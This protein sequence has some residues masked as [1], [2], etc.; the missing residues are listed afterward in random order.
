MI[1]FVDAYVPAGLAWLAEWS[2]RWGVLIALLAAWFAVCPPRRAATRHLLSVVALMA[3]LLLP[4][5]PR[6]GSGFSAPRIDPGPVVGRLAPIARGPVRE[7]GPMPVEPRVAVEGPRGPRVEAP[8]VRELPA[9][10]S[11]LKIHPLLV[12]RIALLAVAACWAA[13]AAVVLLRML[14]GWA[15]LS[16]MRGR[17]TPAGGAAEGLFEACRAELGARRRARLAGHEAVGSPIAVGGWSPVVLVPVDWDALPAPVQRAGLLHELAHLE[18]GDDWARLGEEFVRAAFWFHPG[19]LWLLG[20]IDRERELLCDEAA[21]ARGIAPRE[22]ARML[23]DFAKRPRVLA[24]AP[25]AIPFLSRGT[26]KARIDR[27]L[28]DDVTRWM[29]PLP[30]GRAMLLGL[31]ILG[32][33]LGA[34]SLRV[35]GAGSTPGRAGGPRED[36]SK[37]GRARAPKAG[38]ADAA[39]RDGAPPMKNDEPKGEPQVTVRGTVVDAETGRPITRFVEQ[40]GQVDPK[41]P[42]RITWGFTETRTEGENL[43]GTFR[44]TLGGDFRFRIRIL[45]DGYV[46]QPV[47]VDPGEVGGREV[48]VTVKMVRGRQVSG[49]VLDHGGRPVKAT[50]F[51]VGALPLNITGGQALRSFGGEETAATKS[52]T[53]AEGRFA[54]A[55]RGDGQDRVAVS[56]PGV[57]DLW[58]VPA[59]PPGEELTVRLPEPGRLVLR[60]DI[61]GSDDEARFLLQH[62]TWEQKGWDRLDNIRR[63]TA[64]NGGGVVLSDLTPGVYSLTRSRALRVGDMGQDVLC[65]RRTITVESGKDAETTF[66]RDRGQRVSGQVVGLDLERVTGA[67]IYVRPAEAT[68]DPRAGD[69]WEMPTF[70]ALTCGPNGRFR[71]GRLSPGEYTVV[72]EVYLPEAPEQRRLSGLRVADLVGTAKV[73]VPEEGAAPEVRIELKPRPEPGAAAKDEGPAWG[74]SAEGVQCRLKADKPRWEE[75]EVP[76]LKADVRNQGTQTLSV[77]QAQE[78]CELEVDGRW[79]FWAGAIDIKSSAFGPGRLYEGIRVTLDAM[80]SPKDGGALLKLAPGRHTVR[81][82]FLPSRTGEGGG[83]AIRA[84]SEPVEVEIAPK[85]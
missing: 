74:G 38:P 22:F 47:A 21:V 43:T 56:A 75:G 29:T 35:V 69:R 54:I 5:L 79:H 41:D 26:V 32:L 3:G 11:A 30:R 40:G 68:G 65:D 33:A 15:V 16:R 78:L 28:E 23:L 82:A 1:A 77:A 51:L 17:A 24:A 85:E 34:G 62:H 55:G 64:P 4:A 9:R 57:L 76:S 42:K 37:A 71:T 27:L 12:E 50:A 19:V 72:A 2:I 80:W 49:R 39:G 61:E 8:P 7:V 83:K 59:P 53:D 48:E 45:A 10:P 18:R 73:R 66:V 14:I 46:P 20:R 70:D 6:W 52:A 60:Y 36:E 81:I 67:F 63:P 13:G 44:S 31:V 58:V 25:Q 84:V